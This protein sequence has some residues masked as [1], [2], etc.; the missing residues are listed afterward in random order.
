MPRFLLF[1]F[2]ILL[3]PLAAPR[4]AA[5]LEAL[6][7]GETSVAAAV[8]DG[9]TL[10]L[11]NGTEVR[12]VGIQAPKLPLGRTGFK[13]WPLAEEAKLA[14]EALALGRTFTLFYGGRKV[15]R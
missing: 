2:V 14:L 4:A 5:F 11:E 13:A 9:D 10:V 8:V 12:L 1:F 3:L 7:Q 15:D 6:E